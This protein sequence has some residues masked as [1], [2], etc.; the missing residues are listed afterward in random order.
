VRDAKAVI[1]KSGKYL[2]TIPPYGYLKDPNDKEKWI[3]DEEAAKVVK[4]IFDLCNAVGI[5]YLP[6]DEEM[7]A[8][9]AERRAQK[10]QAKQAKSA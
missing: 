9:E 2:C 8:W 3:V 4:Y 5:I 1:G 6:T 7:D 10:Q